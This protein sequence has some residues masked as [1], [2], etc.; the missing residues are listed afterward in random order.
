MTPSSAC[1]RS[2]YDYTTTVNPYCR[3]PVVANDQGAGLFC[4]RC[5]RGGREE[6]DATL[7]LHMGRGGFCFYLLRR[8][9]LRR[10]A[11]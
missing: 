10:K 5:I 9:L 6:A 3:M 11:G 1:R 4:S 8:L 7:W 2:I